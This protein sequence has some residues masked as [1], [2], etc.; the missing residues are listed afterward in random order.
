MMRALVTI[1][2]AGACAACMPGAGNNQTANAQ[3]PFDIEEVPPPDEGGGPT[4][5]AFA[6]VT[7]AAPQGACAF[8]WQGQPVTRDALRTEARAQFTAA[9]NAQGGATALT[10]SNM[11]H[12]RV[13]ADAA[14][15][16]NCVALALGDLETAGM[17][18]VTL[19]LAGASA[20]TDQRASIF[21][22]HTGPYT[23]RAIVQMGAGSRIAWDEHEIDM[24][25][26]A[27]RAHGLQGSAVTPDDFVLVPAADTNFGAVHAAIGVVRG[28]GLELF[29][30]ACKRE[31][32]SDPR[33]RAVWG[34]DHPAP[35][36]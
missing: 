10:E 23:P 26:L 28:A 35:M 11:P 7:V 15:P 5:E 2:M 17:P 27:S 19:R 16:F 8:T 30:S 12:A 3:N 4:G 1:L 21:N 18:A 34:S 36:C 13:E 25:T 20:G 29:L 32:S 6:V 33:S 24:A 9:I 14:L 22:S 31:A